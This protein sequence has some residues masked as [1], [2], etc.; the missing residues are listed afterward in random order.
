MKKMMTG[1]HAAA[2]GAMLSR[3]EVIAAY[4]ITPQTQV[5]EKLA[6]LCAQGKL[7]AKYVTVESEYSAMGYCIGASTGGAR[8]FTASSSQGLV[9]MQEMIHW[10]GGSRLP[11]V[12]VVVNRGLCSPWTVGADQTD[13]LSQRDTGWLQFYCESN[14]EILDTVIQSYKIAEQI[15]LPVMVIYEGFYLSHTV[16]IVNLPDI[17]LVDSYLP[18]YEPQYKMDLE[19]P[20]TFGSIA[21]PDHYFRFRYEIQKAMEESKE[22][23]KKAVKEYEMIF[24]R[25]S[26]L[27]E[28][29]YCD[30][31]EVILVVSGSI[32]GTS[33]LVV[34]KLRKEGKKV[35]MVKIKMFRPFPKEEIRKILRN[36]EKIAVIDRNIS[37]GHGG[38]FCQEVKSVLNQGKTKGSPLVYGYIAGI[39]GVDITYQLIEKVI[40]YTYNE[41]PPKDDIIWAGLTYEGQVH[42]YGFKEGKI[43]QD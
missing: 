15:L 33:R 16:E 29:Y 6:E 7:N 23:I 37:F 1:N 22:I 31:A 12:M 11:I 14:Q 32:S 10:A 4:P 19:N 20:A 34:D 13:S 9:F 43:F 2:Y 24:G 21:G 40:D 42:E 18:K 8:T 25:K 39:G 27:V 35:G 28:D 17:E 3:V 30:D 38:I 41:E 26:D 36:A 5:A